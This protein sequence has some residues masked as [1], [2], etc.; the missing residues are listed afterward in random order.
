MTEAGFYS[1]IVE[2]F[3]LHPAAQVGFLSRAV[4]IFLHPVTF[5]G[6]YVGQRL[7]YRASRWKWPGITV[8]FQ[9]DSGTNLFK[10]GK[11]VVGIVYITHFY[12]LAVEAGFYSNIEECLPL[13]PLAQVLFPPQAVEIFLHPMI[14]G[15]QYVGSPVWVSGI[16]MEMSWNYSV[17]PSRFG[18][19]SI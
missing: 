12:C 1:Y 13:D 6:Q 8:W 15:G 3:P 9:V 10:A 14:F 7:G 2:C 17:V 5:G 18:D 4:W 19:E 11:Y 16:K